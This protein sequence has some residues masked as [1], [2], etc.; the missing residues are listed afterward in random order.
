MRRLKWPAL[1]LAIVC[2]CGRVSATA[3]STTLA[4][5][6]DRP[7]ALYEPGETVTFLIELAEGG[8]PVAAAE[9][10]CELSTDA[11]SKSEKVRVPIVNGKGQLKASRDKPCV[12]W[13]RATWP[14]E[15]DGRVR[16]TAGA[17]F[18]LERIEPS[19]PPPED[20]DEFWEAQLARLARIPINA[21]LEPVQVPDAGVE[22]FAVTL[23]N[24]DGTKVYGYLGKPKG[25]GPFP[26]LFQ[27]QWSGVY[28]L[29]PRRVVWPARDGFLT[30]NINAH[31]VPNGRPKE[32]YQ[33]L[34]QGRLRGYS[35]QGRESRETCY[36]L[37]MYLACRRA[38]DYVASRPD[39]DRKHFIVTG[40][41]QG[42]AQAIVTAALSPHVKAVS[43]CA[44]ALC[45]Q[46]ARALPDRAPGWPRLVAMSGGQL[47][48]AH[49]NAAR[50]FDVVNFARNVKVPAL[51]GTS[52]ADLTCP[53]PSVYAAYNVLPGPKRMIL[54]PLAAHSGKRLKW[55]PTS[56]EFLAEHSRN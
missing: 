24:I 12:L 29:E 44:P 18:S 6:T 38:T 36:F 22:V 19:M 47:D 16:T 41:S 28:S 49:A 9:L 27:V 34:T 45:D 53:A 43:A 39:W 21:K 23:D 46:T 54:D 32:Y 31:A 11:F 14:K 51:M 15:G 2:M 3:P 25:D 37:R 52:F 4:I 42:G 30:L 1:V 40:S 10:D 56:A 55:G 50:Y 33:E 48:P 5:R 35:H 17:G 7:G 13:I 8:K 26:A 20:F